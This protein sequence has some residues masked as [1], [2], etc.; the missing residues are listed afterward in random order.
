MPVELS[1]LLNCG[2]FCS[3]SEQECS[4]PSI[5]PIQKT[6]IWGGESST[7]HFTDVCMVPSFGMLALELHFIPTAF[8]LK[9]LI[10]HHSVNKK[11]S[12]DAFRVCVMKSSVL[13]FP[14]WQNCL[15]YL[16]KA[17]FDVQRKDSST[18]RAP[19]V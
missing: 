19:H 17:S 16:S 18:P 3:G 4:H 15:A 11:R 10:L 13:L 8:F 6:L 7:S 9:S 5:T 1:L 2:D 12:C 14:T